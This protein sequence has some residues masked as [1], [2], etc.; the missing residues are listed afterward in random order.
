MP[1][2][3][4]SLQ[5]PETPMVFSAVSQVRPEARRGQDAG[6]QGAGRRLSLADV[7]LCAVA[8]R[9]TQLSSLI[10]VSSIYNIVLASGV[11]HS[12]SVLQI[13]FFFRFFSIIGY[14][15]ILKIVPWA[16]LCCAKLLQSCPTLCD[17][18]DCS[19]PGSSVQGDSPGKNTRVDCR[20]LL[21]GFFPTQGWNW[22]LLQWQAGP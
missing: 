21:Q 17:T 3:R 16:M 4:C 5:H 10:K 1:S 6:T 22:C 15:E 2:D 12:D 11:Q 9:F 13:D 19:P 18:M 8:A 20:A 14:C 7:S